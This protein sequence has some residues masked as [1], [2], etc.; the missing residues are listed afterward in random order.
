VNSIDGRLTAVERRAGTGPD[1]G[2][3]DRELGQVRE[4]KAVALGREDYEDAAVLRDRERD[5]IAQRGERH[6]Q[7]TTAHPDLAS[8]A[9]RVQQLSDEV[10][11]LRGLL[12]QHGIDSGGGGERPDGSGEA[13][14]Q[15]GGRGG[16]EQ[17]G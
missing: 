4:D 10:G 16:Q 15:E 9:E 13:G 1:T 11:R 17:A 3:L 12:R 14:D 7:W 5:L 8:V 6:E 2:D